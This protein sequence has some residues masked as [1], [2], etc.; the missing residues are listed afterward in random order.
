[1]QAV[2]GH[3]FPVLHPD[4]ATAAAAVRKPAG[5]VIA[6]S[7]SAPVRGSA[8]D[9]ASCSGFGALLPDASGLT[10]LTA[11]DWIWEAVS[12]QHQCAAAAAV[13]QASDAQHIVFPACAWAFSYNSHL[14]FQLFLELAAPII[15]RFSHKCKFFFCFSTFSSSF[16]RFFEKF[17]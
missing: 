5:A 13:Q 8:L 1:V 7:V 12:G 11:A 16:A 2:S 17:P 15:P 4:A 6:A 10:A 9:S 3:L 14:S